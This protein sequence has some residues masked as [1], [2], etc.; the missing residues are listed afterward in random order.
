MRPKLSSSVL[1]KN[2]ESFK[3]MAVKNVKQLAGKT[4]LNTVLFGP[5]HSFL[6]SQFERENSKKNLNHKK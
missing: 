3:H 2:K 5:S 1:M 6:F 4:E